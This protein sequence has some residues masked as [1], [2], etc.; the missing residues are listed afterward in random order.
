MALLSLAP[1]TAV[2]AQAAP[3]S[4]PETTVWTHDENNVKHPFVYGLCR[5]RS[6]AVLAFCEGRVESGDDTPHHLLLKRSSDRGA[7]WSQSIFI[8]RSERGECFANPTPVVDGRTGRVFLFYALNV[9]NARTQLL[10]RTSDD[11]G[12]SWSAR[13]DLTS[14]FDAD[15]LK[16][17]FH[18]PGPGHGIQ[19]KA[20]R[21]I[22]PVWHR[23]PLKLPSGKPVDS[24]ERQYATSLLLSDDGG[25]HW[26]AGQFTAAEFFANESRV[27]ELA[28]GDLLLNARSAGFGDKGIKRRLLAR[29]GDH[30]ETWKTQAWNEAL[31][32]TTACD[33]GFL[34]LTHG[35]AATQDW[36]L[37]SWPNHPA[38]RIAMTVCLSRDGGHSWPAQREINPLASYSDLV[39]LD[40]GS[41]GLLYG[42]SRDVG[43]ARFGLEWLEAANDNQPK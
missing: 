43:F 2:N 36:L 26:H 41:I 31:P 19:T 8:E 1:A 7:T 21:L 37:F 25:Q 23:L 5:S 12:I 30:G 27:V 34:R 39:E 17:P 20:G 29:S 40:D 9:A 32:E 15:P 13:R 11:E 38:K 16:R 18:L 6:G 4:I 22:V 33:G 28:G 14:L 24:K 35:A 3:A 10:C 42:R